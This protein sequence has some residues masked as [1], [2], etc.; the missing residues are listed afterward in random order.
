MPGIDTPL[1][2]YR[3][4]VLFFSK[5]DIDLTE[6]KLKC[7]TLSNDI[8]TRNVT[9]CSFDRAKKSFSLNLRI[10]VEHVT[11]FDILVQFLDAFELKVVDGNFNCMTSYNFIIDKILTSYTEFDYH[12]VECAELKITGIYK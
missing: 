5:N 12:S 2:K 3:F 10:P 1:Q 6:K 11:E 4:H 8:L 9:S 7:Q